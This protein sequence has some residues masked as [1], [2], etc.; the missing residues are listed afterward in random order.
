[1]YSDLFVDFHLT[2]CQLCES[3]CLRGNNE[4]FSINMKNWCH[5]RMVIYTHECI[6][7]CVLCM[8]VYLHYV[9][10]LDADLTEANLIEQMDIV[11]KYAFIYRLSLGLLCT[12]G[13]GLSKILINVDSVNLYQIQLFHMGS[14]ATEFVCR[15]VQLEWAHE[16]CCIFFT[17]LVWM[18]EE[19]M[20]ISRFHRNTPIIRLYVGLSQ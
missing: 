1:M 6:S 3:E 11:M 8:C 18:N 12:H 20:L 14:N 4:S 5:R 16:L 13:N 10:R 9:M 17:M 19:T 15:Q 2:I 7:A